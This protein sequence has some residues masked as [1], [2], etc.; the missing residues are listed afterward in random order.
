MVSGIIYQN[1]RHLQETPNKLGK[2]NGTV[3]TI[4]KR[5]MKRLFGETS[6]FILQLVYR[7]K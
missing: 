4:R 6:F 1:N 5:I 2:K 7:K 3:F